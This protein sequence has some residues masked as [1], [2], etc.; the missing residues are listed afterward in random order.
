MNIQHKLTV[1]R[2]VAERLNEANITWAVGASLLLYFKGI[3]DRFNDIDIMVTE[4]DVFR[5][6]DIMLS[7]GAINPPNPNVQY[8]T[9]HFLE[10]VVDGVDVDVMAG[11]IIVDDGEEHDC[12][13]RVDQI[14]EYITVDGISVPLQ[15]VALWRRYYSLMHR[16]CKVKMIDEAVSKV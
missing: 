4:E 12:S 14:V 5:L 9:R 2:K 13:L 15:S 10:F 16:D 11:F 1:L 8:K 7:V 6:K 3:T